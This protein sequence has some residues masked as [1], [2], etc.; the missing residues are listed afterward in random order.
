MRGLHRGDHAELREARHVG[1]GDDLG[2]LDA[3]ARIGD[4]PLGRRHRGK[5]LFVLVERDAVAAVADR[6]G[7]DLDAALEP[8][9][10]DSK[11]LLGRR[12]VEAA[13]S[14]R[15]AVWL[16]ERRAARAKR[17]VHVEL[18]RAH[19]EARVATAVVAP[20]GEQLLG[21]LARPADRDVDAKLHAAGGI[22]PA[23][24]VDLAPGRAGLLQLGPAEPHVMR[25]AR[26]E[27]A[28]HLL[29]GHRRNVAVD[30]FHGRVDQHAGRLAGRV[31]QDLP[32]GRVGRVTPD[33]RHLQSLRV[34]Y[35]G[36][37]VDALQDDRTVAHDRVEVPARREHGRLPLRLDPVRAD[38]P[39]RTI[40][41]RA[42]REPA[43]QRSDALDARQVKA[44]L[45]LSDVGEVC[46]RV[47]EAGEHHAPREID[48]LHAAGSALA[49]R[50][51]VADIRD[52]LADRED[53]LRRR[54][55]RISGVNR[56][57]VQ[58]KRG[59]L[60]CDGRRRAAERGRGNQ[61]AED[62]AGECHFRTPPSG[63]SRRWSR[64]R[65]SKR[66]PRGSRARR[67]CS[68]PRSRAGRIA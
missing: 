50:R 15:V 47:G 2:V 67:A 22:K 33:T 21:I 19:R 25:G 54:L 32:A 65:S 42:L 66:C 46:V 62:A 36:V 52:L 20:A 45:A 28:R 10:R 58:Q 12:H 18:D 49:G 17:A 7:L 13:V 56:S 26:L 29:V 44:E 23:E 51:L 43:L 9:D 63:F 34:R 4:G 38:D 61:S 53:R 27:E 55:G 24:L 64:A 48:D 41:G 14:G 30:E 68:T 3:K 60:L 40:R 39:G 31:A 6:V 59:R 57:A 1:V 8:G 5:R 35:R 37:A 16:V 11:D